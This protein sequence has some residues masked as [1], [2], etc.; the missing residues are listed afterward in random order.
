MKPLATL[1]R[2]IL[3]T[4]DVITKEAAVSFK[5]RTDV[6]AVPAAGVVAETMVAMVLATEALRKFGGD[7]VAEF[8]RNAQG[9][10][11]TLP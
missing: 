7:S 5:E 11:A 6:T 10:K 2:P 3:K 9:F 8:V 4:V 1:N